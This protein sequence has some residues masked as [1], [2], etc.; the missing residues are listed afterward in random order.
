MS[1]FQGTGRQSRLAL[2][3]VGKLPYM[4][5]TGYYETGLAGHRHHLQQQPEQQLRD[6]AAPIVGGRQN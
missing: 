1:E 4:T 6:A 2:K 3:A 5:M